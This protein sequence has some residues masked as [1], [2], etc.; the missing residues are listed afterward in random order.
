MSGTSDT[1][2][3]TRT[4]IDVSATVEAAT[5]YIFGAVDVGSSFSEDFAA[6]DVKS[7]A[8]ALLSPKGG[9]SLLGPNAEARRT[10]VGETGSVSSG[11]FGAS[12]STGDVVLL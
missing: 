10:G 6:D 12:S 8:V 1:A 11:C 5:W 3:R 4:S 2:S 7:S 9:R